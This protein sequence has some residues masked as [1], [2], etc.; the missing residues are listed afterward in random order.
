MVSYIQY[1]S[2]LGP[3]LLTAN[4]R[5]LTGLW[6]NKAPEPGWT[7]EETPLLRAASLWLDAYFRGEDQPIPFPLAPAGT[8][9]QKAVWEILL[10]IPLGQTRTYGSIAREMA[11]L[12]GKE[13][14]SAQAVGQAVGRNPISIL[15]PCHRCVGAKGQLTG[16]AGGLDRKTW[17][18]R[19]E[20]HRI[21]NGKIM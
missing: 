4:G 20:G 16:Y 18:L 15:I 21:D 7:P 14:M 9:F 10:S 2:P 1:D 17:L 13:A 3:L 8:P 11:G 19:H 6:I 12:L 5:A